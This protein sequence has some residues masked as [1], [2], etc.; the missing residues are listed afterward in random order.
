MIDEA[1][2]FGELKF[3]ILTLCSAVC[4]ARKPKA[5][6]TPYRDYLLKRSTPHL[7]GYKSGLESKV[8]AGSGS[9]YWLILDDQVTAESVLYL[10]LQKLS[11]QSNHHQYVRDISLAFSA[12][13]PSMIEVSGCDRLKHL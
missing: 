1:G 11:G 12:M 2:H 4:R 8:A 9:A 10:G 3:R 7:L 6:L 5:L 13:N